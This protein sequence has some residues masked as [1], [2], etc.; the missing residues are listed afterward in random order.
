MK[1]IKLCAIA[2]SLSCV[3]PS[4]AESWPTKTFESVV[5]TSLPNGLKTTTRTIND[6]KG[7]M[8]IESDMGGTK[9]ITLMNYPKHELVTL[10]EAQKMALTNKLPYYQDS[11]VKSITTTAQGTTVSALQSYS[12]NPHDMP[13]FTIP[14]GYKVI[15]SK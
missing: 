6:G 2:F 1:M 11:S 15:A 14:T 10:L 4:Y 7:H 3:L 5:V 12:T 9:S 13:A 8:R